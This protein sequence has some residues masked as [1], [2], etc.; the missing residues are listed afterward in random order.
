MAL[1]SALIL[2]ALLRWGSCRVGMMREYTS[3]SLPEIDV[4]AFKMQAP[5]VFAHPYIS[6]LIL[7]IVLTNTAGTLWG[8][9]N[10]VSGKKQ[11]L[12]DEILKCA[13]N[14]PVPG[15]QVVWKDLGRC[16]GWL[17]PPIAWDFTPEQVIKLTCQLKEGCL[18]YPSESQ[19][20]LTVYW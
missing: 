10:S 5:T 14:Y 16:L 18:A 2:M 17:S 4:N 1:C 7:L 20:P 12:G 9:W 8:L 11:T 13:L 6:C 19:Q 3:L 15:W